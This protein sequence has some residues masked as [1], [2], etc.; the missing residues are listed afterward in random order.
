MPCYIFVFVGKSVTFISEHFCSRGKLALS[1]KG[2]E[3][4]NG[5]IQKVE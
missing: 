2:R 4:I 5:K 3:G 1:E